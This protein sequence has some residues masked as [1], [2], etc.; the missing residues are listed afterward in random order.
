MTY[1]NILKELRIIAKKSHIIHQE[2]N[3]KKQKALLEYQKFQLLKEKKPVDEIT[4]QIANLK[5]DTKP[6]TRF[7][8]IFKDLFQ[9]FSK[10]TPNPTKI[11]KQHFK[12]IHTF[13]TSQRTYQELI[14]RYNPGI[15][16]KQAENVEKSANRVGLK[17]PGS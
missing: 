15:N 6:P 12:N 1:K 11:Q 8:E 3:L 16:M 5:V 14:E 10:E 4:K 9:E 2:A 17:V 7:E 13:L